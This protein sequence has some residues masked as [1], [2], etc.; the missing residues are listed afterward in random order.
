VG[1]ELQGAVDRAIHRAGR[2]PGL[3]VVGA[4]E[5]AETAFAS[6]GPLPDPP[7]PPERAV[8]EIGS[9]TK[10]FTAL[11]LAT[12]VE[13]GEVSFDD[14]VVEHLPR[15]TRMPMLD[16]RTITL[17]HLATHTSGLPRLPPGFILHAIRHRDDPYAHLSKEDV[18]ATLGKTRPRASAG[19]RF[20]Y[21]NF[22]AGLLGIAL[23]HAAATDYETLVRERIATPLGLRDTVITLSEDQ[24]SRLAAGTKWRGGPAGLWTV[25]GLTGAGALRS[26]A[27]DVLT[28]IRAQMGTLP[29]VPQELAEA[30]RSSHRDRA[31]GGR[32]TPG[33]RVALGWLL[34]GIGRQKLRIAMHNG[35]TGGYRSFA[36]WAPA[37]EHGVVA[38]S[39]N[40][41][42]VDRIAT[43]SL[44]DL[45]TGHAASTDG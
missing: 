26:T 17:V 13:R 3:L 12:A 34:V 35:G 39:A 5:G 36:G 33:M 31:S 7:C 25:P 30:I 37:S 6:R 18:L 1:T 32:L 16:G 23:A 43:T 38:L 11:L 9:I 19:E 42:S 15:G 20:R 28:F 29:D 8:F 45:A 22:G 24:R 4:T 2:R 21:S 27:V 41:R 40:V 10:V 14:P 44:L